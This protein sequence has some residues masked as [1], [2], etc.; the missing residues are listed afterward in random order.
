MLYFSRHLCVSAPTRKRA[1]TVVAMAANMACTL[2]ALV[3]PYMPNISDVI[4]QQLLAPPDCNVINAGLV[5]YL[6]AGHKIG[7]VGGATG[8][9]G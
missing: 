7:Q 4:Q 6:P 3:Q 1:G 5:Q 2:S 9:V 8:P